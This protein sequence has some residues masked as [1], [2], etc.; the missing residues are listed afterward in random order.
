M[1]ELEQL[2][3]ELELTKSNLLVRERQLSR[4]FGFIEHMCVMHNDNMVRQQALNLRKLIM[5]EEK[6]LQ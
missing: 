5:E 1:D 6:D 4:A 3:K 2:K